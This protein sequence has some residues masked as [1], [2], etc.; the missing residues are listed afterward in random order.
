MGR[1]VAVA[2]RPWPVPTN[3]SSA[4]RLLNLLARVCGARRVL[5]RSEL[6][7]SRVPRRPY[8]HPD[9]VLARAVSAG[10]LSAAEAEVIDR[11]RLGNV[12]IAQIAF[13]QA[14]G[15]QTAVSRRWRA[16]RRLA[17]ALRSGGGRMRRGCLEMPTRPGWPDR[18][19][20]T[21]GPTPRTMLGYLLV[22]VGH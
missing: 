16:E 10:L 9:L 13:G 1:V 14:V 4:G 18:H 5:P 12:P 21:R 6:P 11:T 2:D 17:V 20:A 22:A 8:W 19:R 3:C 15:V 7:E